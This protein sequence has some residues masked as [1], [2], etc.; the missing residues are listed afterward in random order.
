MIMLKNIMFR[1]SSV[2]VQ[3]IGPTG[4][5]VNNIAMYEGANNLKLIFNFNE[6]LQIFG[7]IMIE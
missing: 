6:N 2:N 7:I 1:N 3:Y 4:C 5:M